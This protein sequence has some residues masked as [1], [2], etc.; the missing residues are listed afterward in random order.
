M[1]PL[2]VHC[3]AEGIVK[4]TEIIDHV[5]PI[6]QGGEDIDDNC[7]GLCKLHHDL[8]TS[9]EA[10]IGRE[11]QAHPTWL[12]KPAIP[13]V[14]V[15][16]P[17]GA[18]KSTYVN[19]NAKPGDVILDLDLINQDLFGRHGHQR[20]K[21]DAGPA[22]W[23]RNRRLAKLANARSGT[24][25]F[26]VSAPTERER[27]WWRETLNAREVVLLDPGKNVC[28][29]RIGPVLTRRTAT[30]QWYLKRFE[31]WTPPKRRGGV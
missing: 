9:R 18:G 7:Q 29:E 12:P 20:R 15:C 21:G 30:E 26:I 31:T 19:A 28:L 25:W 13:V 23:E 8:K 16:G 24:A 27:A 22:L 11:G 1:F 6:A 4:A 3:Q 14:V 5:K 10:S 17:A 2:C